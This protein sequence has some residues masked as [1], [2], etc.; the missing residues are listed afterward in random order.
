MR[1]I[2]L[3]IVFIAISLGMLLG[4]N[5]QE[6]KIEGNKT[7][8]EYQELGL[9]SGTDNFNFIEKQDTF[10]LEYKNYLVKKRLIETSEETF[11]YND[12]KEISV[13]ENSIYYFLGIQNDRFAIFDEGTSATRELMVYD[14]QTE[15][16]VFKI[17][18]QGD[19]F[20]QDNSLYYKTEVKIENEELKPKCPP[21]IE[22]LSYKIYLEEQYFDFQKLKVVHTGN[23]TCSFIE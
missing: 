9:L 23:Y 18:Y 21:D 10:I 17:V 3:T 13:N 8:K 14:L 15:K 5:I 1:K 20:L 11:I 16:E 19:L 6:N 2:T 12:S 4:Q 22:A 7:N